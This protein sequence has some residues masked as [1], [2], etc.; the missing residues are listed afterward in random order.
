[1]VEKD[2]MVGEKSVSVTGSP[3]GQTFCGVIMTMTRDADRV[4][5]VKYKNLVAQYVTYHEE[6][7]MCMFLHEDLWDR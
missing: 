2:Q 1:M 5:P 4:S 3:I 7:G 6:V